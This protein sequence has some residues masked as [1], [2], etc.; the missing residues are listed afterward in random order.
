MIIKKNLSDLSRVIYFLFLLSAIVSGVSAQTIPVT[1]T[2]TSDNK[3]IMLPADLIGKYSLLCF[4]TSNKAQTDL[5]SWMD[6]VYQKFIAKTGIMDDAFDVNVFFI[7][8][9]KGTNAIF[10]ESFKRKIAESAQADLKPHVLFCKSNS[11][12]IAAVMNITQSEIAYLFLLDKTGK[13]IYKTT[14]P[15]TEEK[16][17]AIDDKI[18]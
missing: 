17:D 14:G 16:W 5:E 3:K 18:Q 12:Q 1:E 2:V 15:Y 11:N 10:A 13:I 4:A 7:P 9:L 6:P 8:I